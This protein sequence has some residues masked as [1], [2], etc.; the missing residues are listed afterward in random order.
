A[1]CWNFGFKSIDGTGKQLIRGGCQRPWH[2]VN[3]LRCQVIGFQYVFRQTWIETVGY[4]CLPRR[5]K[6]IAELIPFQS[7]RASDLGPRHL[8]GQVV[9]ISVSPNTDGI[10]RGPVSW[11]VVKV[12]EFEGKLVGMS[13]EPIDIRI[14]A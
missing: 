5:L 13:F 14:D 10:F 6:L 8:V 2:K 3:L 9:Q 7:F 1:F 4:S 12:L 11:L